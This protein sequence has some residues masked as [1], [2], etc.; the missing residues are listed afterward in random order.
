MVSGHLRHDWVTTINVI[1]VLVSCPSSNSLFSMRV[2]VAVVDHVSQSC[3][4]EAWPQ[5]MRAECRGR[6]NIQE[7]RKREIKHCGGFFGRLVNALCQK[8]VGKFTKP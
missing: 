8:S 2:F 1:F 6:G 4:C 7:M 5:P 3:H